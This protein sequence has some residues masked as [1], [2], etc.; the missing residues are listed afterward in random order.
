MV[1]SGSMLKACFYLG[2][3]FASGWWVGLGVSR[4]GSRYLLDGKR[5]ESVGGK[6]GIG[7]YYSRFN[8]WLILKLSFVQNLLIDGQSLGLKLCENVELKTSSNINTLFEK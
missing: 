1:R 8:V 3:G 5:G 6:E 7:V 4:K 2:G